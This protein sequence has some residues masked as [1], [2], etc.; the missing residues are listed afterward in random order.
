M[1]CKQINILNL[2]LHAAFDGPGSTGDLHAEEEQLLK[3]YPQPAAAHK[4]PRWR[5]YTSAQL[6]DV[7]TCFHIICVRATS[8]LSNTGQILC[9]A[10]SLIEA[11]FPLLRLESS[12][13]RT[14][15]VC[16][17]IKEYM[18][19]LAESLEVHIVPA[20]TH[21]GSSDNTAVAVELA[22]NQPLLLKHSGI[23]VS[24]LIVRCVCGIYCNRRWPSPA[25]IQLL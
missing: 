15:S 5:E 17:R 18:N 8:M 3:S 24:A 10:L 2:T 16:E 9:C 1:H 23:E 25:R 11:L 14:P 4:L 7:D 19:G 21:F 13:A 6:V 12:A 22:M 20:V